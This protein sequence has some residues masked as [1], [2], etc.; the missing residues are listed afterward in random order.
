M[1]TFLICLW[2]LAICFFVAASAIPNFMVMEGNQDTMLH[3]TG[4]CIIMM[5]PTIV[6]RRGLHVSLA[7]L[8]LFALGIGVEYMQTFV[9]GRSSSLRD[10]YANMGGLSLGLIVGYLLRP[11]KN[12]LSVK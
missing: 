10:V 8:L 11:S 2:L 1:K 4:F 5:V 9:D 7:A 6:L 3:I 12:H